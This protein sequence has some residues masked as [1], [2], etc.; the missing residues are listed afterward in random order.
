MTLQELCDYYDTHPGFQ[1]EMLANP[2]VWWA[3]EKG[4]IEY[5]I[6]NNELRI[7]K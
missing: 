2:L 7:L 4:E 6:T 5:R 1:E 3:K